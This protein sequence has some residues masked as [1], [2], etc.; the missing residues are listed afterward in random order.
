MNVEP[1]RPI[2]TVCDFYRG[3]LLEWFALFELA[4]FY[5]RIGNDGMIYRIAEVNH[6]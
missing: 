3:D 4:H 2:H 5:F 1:V 6:D